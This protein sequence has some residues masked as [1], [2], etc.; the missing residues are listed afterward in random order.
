MRSNE[1]RP[2]GG[3]PQTIPGALAFAVRQFGADEALVDGD[4]RLSFAAL[5]DRVDVVA[6]ALIASDVAAGDRV[7]IW[8]PNSADWVV[9]SFAVYA[10]GAILVPLNTRYKGEEAGHVLRT[11]GARL[12]FSVTDFIGADLL[13]LLTG[14]PGLD[15]LEELVVM[16]GPLGGG[17]V[18]LRDFIDRAA[19]V[20]QTSVDD[21][22]AALERTDPSDIIFTSGT[23]GKPKGAVLGHGA[24]VRTYLAW[25][26]LVGLR[27][28][29][30][31]L[32]VYP[33]FHTAGLKSGV[34]ACV[35]RGATI[36]PHAV[37]DVLPVMQRVVEERISMLPGTPTVFQSILNHPDFASFDL[38]SLRLSVTGAATVPVEIIRRMRQELRFETVVTGYGLTETTGTVSMCRHDDSPEVIATTVGRPLPGVDVRLVDAAGSPVADGDPGEIL[39]RGFNVMQEYFEDPVATR[40]AMTDGWLRTGD[41]GI[42]GLDGN[43]RIT[44]RKKDMYIVGG[45]NAFPAEI[46]G[47]M[48]AHPGVGQVAVIGVPD[49]R[50]GEVGVAFVVARPGAT[51]DS[52][53]LIAW[54]RDHMAN[55][56]VPRQV[57]VVDALP[58]NPTGKVMKF[59]LR[60]A[61]AVQATTGPATSTISAS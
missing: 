61:Y 55:F 46:E 36:V 38:S 18:T 57:K 16:A 40:E 26:E 2:E 53:E 43:L 50:L 28:A 1:V 17:S 9:I 49:D 42:L 44:D 51:I 15:A 23:T 34:L 14:V 35:L 39:V 45:F 12:L 13:S 60:A 32:V 19:A 25:S 29:D 47:I 3:E 33:F 31:Y 52:D 21:R 11:A 37:F 10:V 41:I 5:Q 59:E 30:R 48:V 6:R 54:C 8:A 22:T 7:A 27:R 20:P 56:K 4:I 58:V 24:S